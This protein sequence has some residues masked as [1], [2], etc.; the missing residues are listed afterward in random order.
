M[1]V[2]DFNNYEGFTFS[3][4]SEPPVGNFGGFAF[5]QFIKNEYLTE[6]SP[7]HYSP[8]LFEDSS[9]EDGRFSSPSSS[10]N[11]VLLRTPENPI[12][13]TTLNPQLVNEWE[14]AMK[15]KW[16][17]FVDAPEGSSEN[18]V[19]PQQLSRR[20][21][22]IV[23]PS[24]IVPSYIESDSDD[25]DEDY[26]PS[27]SRKRRR[28]DSLD[29]YPAIIEKKARLSTPAPASTSKRT[30]VSPL[31]RNT[32]ASRNT[33][34]ALIQKVNCTRADIKNFVCPECGWEQ[35]NHRMPDFKRHLRTH[36]RVD[37]DDHGSGYWCHGVELRDADAYGV[38][39][40]AKQDSFKGKTMVGGCMRS[41]SRRDALKRHLD[42]A[43]MTCVG[44]KNAY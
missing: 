3:E 36:L 41:F 44:Y 26:Q 28:S 40:D 8:S 33:A 4:P 13:P 16:S 34:A 31:S 9:S 1:A 14:E 35:K 18:V 2:Q 25:K 21:S 23:K 17:G 6:A 38:A 5:D 22:S 32:Q 30:R 7:D 37:N 12:A 39:P 11:D 19:D 43:N 15:G 27:S 10:L 20:R 29:L 24:H 42:N